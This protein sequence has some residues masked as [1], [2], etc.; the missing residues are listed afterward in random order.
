[1]DS[2]NFVHR[3][4]CFIYKYKF[5]FTMEKYDA[6]GART[7]LSQE[8]IKDKSGVIISLFF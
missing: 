5:L 1:M 2:A 3:D 4:I 8:M 6:S 7:S